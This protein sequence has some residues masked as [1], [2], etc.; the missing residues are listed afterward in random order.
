MVDTVQSILTSIAIVV[1]ALWAYYKLFRGR[2]YRPRLEAKI[3]GSVTCHN[4]VSYLLATAELKNVGLSK[5]SIL[6][7]ATALE[8][9]TYR[10]TNP[11]IAITARDQAVAAHPMFEAHGWI[12]PD[13]T[14][15]DQRL[16]AIP[17][18]HHLAFRLELKVATQIERFEIVSRIVPAR[19]KRL[20]IFSKLK[21]REPERI[22]WTA[23]KVVSCDPIPNVQS[24]VQT[25]SHQAKPDSGVAQ[26]KQR[27]ITMDSYGNKNQQ[28]QEAH[29]QERLQQAEADRRERAV[30]Q[31][32]QREREEREREERNQSEGDKQ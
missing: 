27:R 31:Q 3:S 14:I 6:R 12:E 13:E 20:R 11:T 4:E 17:G 22:S 29:K 1:G 25:S 16:L 19:I 10:A 15:E 24:Q 30:E 32:A 21:R 2:T 5:V 7:H 23:V 26:V 9:F 28:E 18:C 8:S